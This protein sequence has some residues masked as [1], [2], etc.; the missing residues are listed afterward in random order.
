MT[1]QYL[2]TIIAFVVVL[3]GLSLLITTLNQ[4]ISTLFG[5]RGTNLLWG[6]EKVLSTLDPTLA[7]KAKE[8]AH[9]ILTEP[10]I[11]DSLF[12]RF[13]DVPMLKSI[14][15]RWRIAS[16]ISAQD[17]VH[18]LMKMGDDLRA[19]DPKTS[20]ALDAMLGGVDPE[21]ARKAVLAENLV[22]Q[23]AP[24]DV[25]QANAM[26][27]QLETSTQ[28]TL[29]VVEIWFNRAMDRA[30]QRFALQM[31]LWTVAF[32][33][34]LAFGAHINTFQVLQSLWNSPETRSNL[35]N[36]RD[37]MMQE[38]TV[39]L[40]PAPSGTGTGPAVAPQIVN[41]AMKKLQSQDKDAA[42]LGA[43]PNFSS[44]TEA[45]TW[46]N[47]KADPSRK[48][49][50]VAEYQ[51]LVLNGLTDQFKGIKKAIDSS[52]LVLV[53]NPYPGLFSYGDWRNFAGILVTAAFLSLGAP[54]WFNALKTL[55]NL[56]PVV[57]SKQDAPKP[58][59]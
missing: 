45:I 55:S 26:V 54:F 16:A 21:V 32:A 17:L 37:A 24:G 34:L 29:G 3:L 59:G 53:P 30:S 22:Q 28:Q 13:K 5:Y 23:V 57:A 41:D 46:L 9:T 18:G 19:Q 4:M 27:Q 8:M 35:V 15:S 14:T 1:L 12:S 39:M 42:A 10:I 48:A 6:V 52:G 51:Q 50:L 2:D 38:A 7:G 44:L 40:S 49:N 33:V 47:E 36:N 58:S 25:A 20:A 43:P 56:R 31:R 11:S